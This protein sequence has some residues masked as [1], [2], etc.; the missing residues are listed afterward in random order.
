M[1]TPR[2]IE[3]RGQR[4]VLAAITIPKDLPAWKRPKG[5]LITP[6]QV[7]DTVKSLIAA[8]GIKEYLAY[9]SGKQSTED[10]LPPGTIYTIVF[11]TTVGITK[12]MAQALHKAEK[13]IESAY[14]LRMSG[15]LGPDLMQVQFAPSMPRPKGLDYRD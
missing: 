5:K 15:G 9:D 6:K 3:Y 8:L 12:A 4:Y 7:P 14:A 10:D 1:R 11:R 2:L 13:K